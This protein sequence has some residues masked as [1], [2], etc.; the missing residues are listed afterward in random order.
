MLGEAA[1]GTQQDLEAASFQN[2]DAEVTQCSEEPVTANAVVLGTHSECMA[3]SSVASPADDTARTELAAAKQRA[4]GLAEAKSRAN[5]LAEAKQRATQLAEAKLRACQLADD[6]LQPLGPPL[7]GDAARRH[8]DS[9]LEPSLPEPEVLPPEQSAEAM[10]QEER[11]KRK[12]L[13]DAAPSTFE[14]VG[15][16]ARPTA[17]AWERNRLGS[18]KNQQKF[19]RLMGGRELAETVAERISDEEEEM[20]SFVDDAD[21]PTDCPVFE[22]TDGEFV[23]VENVG[24]GE[25]NTFDVPSGVVED[26]SDAE[27]PPDMRGL[28]R[29]LE[30]HFEFAR[31]HKGQG[32][33][34]T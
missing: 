14:D 28:N 33:G 24:H 8:A 10:R 32:L 23:A 3:V 34:M 16:R 22:L 29:E 31:A 11:Q 12:A 1:V 19:L 9:L 2:L 27:G 21:L 17:N 5:Q 4:T 6:M 13:F 26:T 18:T 25:S 20:G 7:D 15:D 30:R